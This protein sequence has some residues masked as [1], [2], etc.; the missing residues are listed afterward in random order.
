MRSLAF[1]GNLSFHE[2]M[3][4]TFAIDGNLELD[5]AGIEWKYFFDQ[6]HIMPTLYTD[7]VKLTEDMEKKKILL[8]YLPTANYFYLRSR[9]FYLPIANAVSATSGTSTTTSLLIVA[10]DS[11]ITTLAEL[12][13]KTYGYI[14]PYCTSSY[15]SIAILLWKNNFSIRHFF[16]TLKE[17]GPWQEQI[18][19]VT[20]GKVDATMVPKDVWYGSVDNEKKTKVIAIEDNLPSPLILASGQIDPDLLKALKD[21]L[22]SY[23]SSHKSMF[24]GF[25]PYQKMQTE[26]FFAEAAQAFKK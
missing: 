2:A 22:F 14:H 18:N 1:F 21:L 11:P 12:Q 9:D 4:S 24:T 8:C 23:K 13:G 3:Q 16:L 26:R 6:F 20:S 19:A 5:I 25:I 15:F 17:V 10:K 7:M